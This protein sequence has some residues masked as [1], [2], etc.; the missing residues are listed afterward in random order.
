MLTSTAASSSAASKMGTVTPA[1]SSDSSAAMDAAS[2]VMRS[3]TAS[4]GV[5]AVLAPPLGWAPCAAIGLAEVLCCSIL[6]ACIRRGD[7]QADTAVARAVMWMP[8]AG[9]LDGVLTAPKQ[10]PSSWSS[11]M[12]EAAAWP[13]AV[14]ATLSPN[15]GDAPSSGMDD[16]ALVKLRLR[17][18]PEGGRAQWPS[19]L[20]LAV[21]ALARRIATGADVAPEC[22]PALWAANCSCGA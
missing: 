10:R 12:H 6:R 16:V 21:L 4:D 18:D 3:G 13:P 1:L 9:A 8:E 20:R 15:R 19:A 2:H 11:G 7:T 5:P 17:S 22:T 14:N